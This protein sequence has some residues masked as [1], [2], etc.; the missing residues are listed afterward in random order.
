MVKKLNKWCDIAWIIFIYI[1]GVVTASLGAIFWD[2]IPLGAQG[3][4]FVAVIMPLHV[5]EEWKFPGGLHI[6]YNVLL[7]PKEK[8]KQQLNRYPMSRL[9]DM[10]TNVGLQWIPLV[11]LVLCFLQ[12][13]P[14]PSLYVCYY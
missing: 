7:G 14:M 1:T 4:M 3:A 5:L 2:K 8:E 11:Y 13:C 12:G 9:T 10:I 6:F